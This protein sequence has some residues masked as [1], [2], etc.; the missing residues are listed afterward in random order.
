MKG[1]EEQ[2]G[3]QIYVNTSNTWFTGSALQ[4]VDMQEQT[5]QSEA[6]E[7]YRFFEAFNKCRIFRLVLRMIDRVLDIVTLVRGRRL[8]GN[9]CFDQQK[10]KLILFTV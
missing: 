1:N 4:S 8:R 5:V 9:L 2:Q 7:R 3:T 6:S 10:G